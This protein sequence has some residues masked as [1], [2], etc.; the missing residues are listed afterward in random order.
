MNEQVY[1]T[2]KNNLCVANDCDT[3]N[4][5]LESRLA[6]PDV[7]LEDLVNIITPDAHPSHGRVWFRNVATETPSARTTCPAGLDSPYVLWVDEV[8]AAYCPT[9]SYD[10]ATD[11]FPTKLSS[12]FSTGWDVTYFNNYKV[13]EG[14]AIGKIV[15]YQ[16]GT[17]IPTVDGATLNVSIPLTTATVLSTT[18]I[19]FFEIIGQRAAIKGA[20]NTAAVS[21]PCLREAIA[22]GTVGEISSVN[23]APSVADIDAAG[24]D[25]TF[26]GT[27]DVSSLA[28]AIAGA[29][30][31]MA[32]NAEATGIG[33]AEWLEYVS[34]FFNEEAAASAHIGEVVDRI[35]ATEQAVTDTLPTGPRKKVIW[36]YDYFGS[37]YSGTCPNYYCEAIEK[38][39]GEIMDLTAIGD[40][41]AWGAITN[42]TLFYE[43]VAEADI[44]LYPSNNWEESAVL[45]AAPVRSCSYFRRYL[46]RCCFPPLPLREKTPLSATL[47]LDRRVS[48]PS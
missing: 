8:T 42:T 23:Y 37:I 36:A 3:V 11:Y 31:P 15:A 28:G 4:D 35:A 21:S 24:G 18:Y 39:G 33:G 44:W 9:G 48:A 32:E 20:S 38:A 41:A 13:I 19:P 40:P 2:T 45:A 10:A 14:S 26:A 47:R 29:A 27:Y 46:L 5:W 7:L 1:D 30:I 43:T 6:E 16:C 12:E 25:A 22:A 17:P 34:L